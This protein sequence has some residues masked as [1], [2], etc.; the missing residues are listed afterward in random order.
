MGLDTL[1]FDFYGLT[2]I[3]LTDSLSQVVQT[4]Y[5]QYVIYIYKGKNA[6]CYPILLSFL[7]GLKRARTTRT[8]QSTHTDYFGC[9]K[10]RAN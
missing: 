4:M 5:V 3:H 7:L 6:G 2:L 9:R 1:L 8:L 10:G